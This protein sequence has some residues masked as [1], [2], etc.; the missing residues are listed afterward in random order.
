MNLLEETK[1]INVKRPTWKIKIEKGLEHN[2]VVAIMST[3]TIY[4]LFFDDIRMLA[5]PIEAD[6]IVFGITTVCF[7]MFCIET[8][9]ASVSKEGYFLTF[10]FFLD[11]ISTLSMLTDIGWVWDLMTGGGGSG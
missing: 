6:D 5:L 2:I 3:I 11:V 10:F 9:L 4:S 7:C 8:I 1:E